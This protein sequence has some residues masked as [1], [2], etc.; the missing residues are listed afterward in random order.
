MKVFR[1]V[2]GRIC[3][4]FAVIAACI[5]GLLMVATVADVIRRALTDKSVPGL[6]E[7]S[8]LL[9]LSAVVMGLGYAELTGTHVRTGLVTD[10]INR[11][12]ALVYRG[13]AALIGAALIAWV[14]YEAIGK[15]LE[16]YEAHE[17]TLG[18]T[19]VVTWP[20]KA[21]V[22]VGFALFALQL[23]IRSIDDWTEFAT[24]T[25]ASTSGGAA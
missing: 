3:Q 15:A 20:A 13:T 7:I 1:D 25:G 8:P 10:R 11:R 19:P 2:L 22:P 14:G 23:L 18:L 6:V 4:T 21:L 5:Y 9:L 16:A 17:V 12:V 24:G